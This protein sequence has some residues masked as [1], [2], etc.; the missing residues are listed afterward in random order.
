[1]VAVVTLMAASAV[2]LPGKVMTMLVAVLGAAFGELVL[3]C[4]V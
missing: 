2:A 1:M 4:G 3:G